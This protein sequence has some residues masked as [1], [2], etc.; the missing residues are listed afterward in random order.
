[1]PLINV[2]DIQFDDEATAELWNSRY[3]TIVNLLNGNLDADNLAAGAVTS[4]KLASGAAS[5][6]LDTGSVVQMIQTDY[7]AAATSAGTTIPN[8]DTAPQNTEGDEYM[9]QAITPKSSTNVLVVEA[10]FYGSNASGSQDVI[11]A[12]FRD[13]TASAFA[14]AATFQA[15]ATGTVAIKVSGKVTAGSTSPTTFKLRAGTSAAG[16]TTFNG[17]SGARKFGATDKS[18]IRVTEYKA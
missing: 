6:N 11:T 13:S 7:T 12:L 2:P 5:A 3:A 4:A 9:S 17:Q 8:D 16:T 1:M 14:V 15:T 10:L 18:W